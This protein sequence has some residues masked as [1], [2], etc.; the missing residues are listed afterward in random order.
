MLN[1]KKSP[2]TA[3]L[4]FGRGEGHRRQRVRGHRFRESLLSLRACIRAMNPGTANG[5]W[6]MAKTRKIEKE[7]EQRRRRIAAVDGKRADQ[8]TDRSSPSPWPSPPGEGEIAAKSRVQSTAHGS[9]HPLLTRIGAM[10][11]EMAKPRKNRP[12]CG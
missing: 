12:E 7:A 1:E 9:F 11:P 10:N 6:Q 3:P 8:S 4:P 2:P 5:R